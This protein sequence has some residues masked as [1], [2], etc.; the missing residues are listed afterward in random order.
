MTLRLCINVGSMQTNLLAS[1][2]LK[3]M[4]NKGTKSSGPQSGSQPGSRPSSQPGF[5]SGSQPGS[6]TAGHRRSG[7]CSDCGQRRPGIEDGDICTRYERVNIYVR[8]HV[9]KRTHAAACL[10]YS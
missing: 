10:V 8:V 1:H 9:R 4:G 6:Q 3:R 2:S 5:Q 7:T